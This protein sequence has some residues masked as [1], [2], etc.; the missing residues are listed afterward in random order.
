VR[1][2]RVLDNDVDVRQAP[3]GVLYLKSPYALGPYPDRLTDKLDEWAVA[4]PDRVF[5]ADR[6]ASGGEADPPG[7][8]RAVTFREARDRARSIAQALI[9][10]GLNADRP[11]VILSGNSVDHALLALGAMYAGVYYAPIA[12]AYSLQSKTDFAALRHVF[13]KVRPALVFADDG[14]AFSPALDAVMTAE[15]EL[16]S[17]SDVPGRAWTPFGDLLATPATGAVDDA[18]RQVGPD[19]IA[20]VLFT[21]G[22]TGRPKGVINTQRMWCANQEQLRSVMQFLG[23]EPPVLCDWLPWNHTAG[24]NHNFGIV[25]YNGGTMYID[26]GK[27]VAGLFDR[28]LRNLREIACTNHFTVPRFYEMLLP[29][30]QRD[31]ELR[32][33][34]FRRLN[35]IFYAAAG[36]GQRFWDQLREVAVAECG[37]ELLIMTGM[38]ATETAP[39]LMCTGPRGA[40]AG[41]IGL[42]VPG[43]EL[44]LVPAGEKVEGRF[45][46][47]NITPGYLGEPDLTQAAFDDEGFYRSGDAMSLADASDPRAGLVFEGRLAEDFKLSSGTWVS[48][49]PLRARLIA[50][51][52]G[53]VQ[54]VV[55]A[56]PD[57]EYAAALILPNVHL[58]REIAGLAGAPASEVLAHPVVRARFEAIVSALAAAGTG[59]STYVARAIVLDQP[60]SSG[61]REITDKGSINQKA[62]LHHRAAIVDELYA[63]T[64]SA[65]VIVAAASRKEN[66][67][68]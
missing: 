42:P 47:P 29:H 4:A 67:P 9:N 17:V 5:L 27:P 46:G 68:R 11:L 61:A 7:G 2:V 59:S 15:T 34:F 60:P 35:L 45:R 57:R 55:I 64:P 8:W 43:V 26:D 33:V 16:V 38:G 13:E 48:V 39:F 65:R 23:D 30:L 32:E 19:T 20:K 66:K 21:S 51:G 56:A 54:D 24:G 3:G 31:A 58:C 50:Q 52:A 63:A 25:L 37:E 44:K 41:M 62:V 6:A 18:C 53:L 36:L 12:P 40:F 28:T 14:I 22:S 1:P 10:R 49:G